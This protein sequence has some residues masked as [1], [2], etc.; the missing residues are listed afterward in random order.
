MSK[1]V[2][3]SPSAQEDNI[4]FGKFGTEEEVMNKICNIVEKILKEHKIIVYRNKP[5]MNLHNIVLDSNECNPTIHFAI[6]SNAFN[7]KS[8]GCE[9]FCHKFGDEG[10]RLAKLVYQEIETITPTSDR[11]IKQGYNFYGTGKSIF[12]LSATIAPA[13][14]IE[15]AF[16]DNAEDSKWI[17]DNIEKIGRKIAI[18]ILAYFNI[19]YIVPATPVKENIVYR[20]ISGSFSEK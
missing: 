10:H 9:V 2:Y 4:G 1:S 19:V 16:H 11:G 8:R 5:K 15:I 13:A 14:L 12:E 7:T 20:V 17:L 6:H 3:L 18:G